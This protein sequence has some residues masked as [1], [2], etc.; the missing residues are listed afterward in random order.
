MVFYCIVASN[1]HLVLFQ[2]K[3]SLHVKTLPG[4]KNMMDLE[5]F[6]YVSYQKKD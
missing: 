4:S 6:S 1:M 5:V 2:F 3:Q